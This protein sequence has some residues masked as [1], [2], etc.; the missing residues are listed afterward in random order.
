MGCHLINLEI[1]DAGSGSF[2]LRTAEESDMDG[3]KELYFQVYGGKYTLPEVT[4]TDKMKWAINDPNYLWL[5]IE[6]EGRLIG[7]VL[8]V[9]DAVHRLGKSLAGVVLPEFRGINLM[10]TAIKK[11]IDYCLYE[12][13]IVDVIYG[14]VRTFVPEG[15]H[16]DLKEMGFVDLGIFP[17]VRKVSQYETHGLKGLFKPE[18]LNVRKTGPNLI[19]QS[20]EIYAIVKERLRLEEP[21]IVDYKYQTPGSFVQYGFNVEK[22]PEIE[23]EYYEKR[24]SKKLLMSFY[25]FHYPEIRL[26]T[27]DGRTSAYIH[28]EE[29]D[30][31]GDLMGLETDDEDNL[32]SILE[33]VAVK[34]E[35]MG[36]RYLE[37]LVDAFNYNQQIRA[38]EADF[39][40]C[41][42]FPAVK[43]DSDGRRTDYVVMCRNFIPLNFRGIKLTDDTRAYVRAYYKLR[44][45]KLW[46]D[47]SYA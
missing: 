46:E 14:V 39:C 18:A 32:T 20:G 17:N 38:F 43:M 25:P 15:F 11:G 28:F 34:A 24:D 16:R 8:F 45:T 31:H 44:S 10:K 36:I 26:R 12:K 5:V 6:R 19:P 40:P 22:S 21:E 4:S 41:A 23:W 27:D 42:Y 33:S 37:L 35:S 30:G 29:R 7:S 9:T 47:M 1:E 3:L 2:L 13:N